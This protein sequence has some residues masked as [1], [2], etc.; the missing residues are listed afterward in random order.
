MLKQ[1]AA[2]ALLL[3]FA[4]PAFAQGPETPGLDKRQAHMEQRIEQGKASGALNEKQ[5]ARLEQRKANLQKAED[6]AKAD[7]K[8]TRE[9]RKRLD[10]K[11]DRVSRDIHNAK[12]NPQTAAPAPEAPKQ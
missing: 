4:A 12:H 7:G 9:E 8:V 10:R 3:A 1:F 6:R 11:A 2:A 5:A